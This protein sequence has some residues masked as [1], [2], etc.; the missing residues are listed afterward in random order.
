MD[1]GIATKVSK[2]ASY[3]M[4]KFIEPLFARH[5]AKWFTYISNPWSTVIPVL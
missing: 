2:T 3:K 5:W 4:A 1:I